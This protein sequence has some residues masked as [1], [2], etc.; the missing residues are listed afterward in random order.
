MNRIF[1]EKEKYQQ[2]I[3]N[4]NS[5]IERMDIEK[6][7]RQNNFIFINEQFQKLK[8]IYAKTFEEKNNQT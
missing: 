2:Q 8:E 7:E 1:I 5:I 3:I 6:D 4:L